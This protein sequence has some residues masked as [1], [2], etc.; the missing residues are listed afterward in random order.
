MN[1]DK[2][3]FKVQEASNEFIQLWVEEWGLDDKEKK[4][5]PLSFSYCIWAKQFRPPIIAIA[6]V[7]KAANKHFRRKFE[8]INRQAC[9]RDP[10]NKAGTTKGLQFLAQEGV[11]KSKHYV[12][13]VIVRPGIA[14][15]RLCRE[16]KVK[17]DWF[18]KVCSS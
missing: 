2:W 6:E 4:K 13:N 14:F 5:I 15:R 12:H 3:C 7:N 9:S 1:L 17:P 8:L 10:A 18:I 16:E 11:W